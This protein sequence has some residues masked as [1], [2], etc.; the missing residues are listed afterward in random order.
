MLVL[1]ISFVASDEIYVVHDV[2]IKASSPKAP[3]SEINNCETFMIL[4]Q[5]Q[6]CSDS[7]LQWWWGLIRSGN[8][9]NGE[10]EKRGA[11]PVPNLC[12]LLSRKSY[13]AWG[14]AGRGDNLGER[15]QDGEDGEEE[16]E[17]EAFNT[18]FSPLSSTVW[19]GLMSDWFCDQTWPKQERDQKIEV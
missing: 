5:L 13:I 17:G 2:A 19:M 1:T 12:W 11:L 3:L 9:A 10:G 15:G 14:L 16:V 8:V 18:N 7:Q 6:C 4:F